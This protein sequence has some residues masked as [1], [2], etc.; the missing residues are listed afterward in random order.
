MFNEL[1]YFVIVFLFHVTCLIALKYIILSPEYGLSGMTKNIYFIFI[2]I[3]A[4][5][6]LRRVKSIN[7]FPGTLLSS[8]PFTHIIYLHTHSHTYTK[9]DF[10]NHS[11]PILNLVQ[12]IPLIFYI[13]YYIALI[14]LPL[15]IYIYKKNNFA[16]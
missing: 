6:N 16:F 14:K 4:T 12:C 13:Q 3:L 1:F 2:I 8:V 7:D 11:H 5:K 10:L 9:G 15:Y